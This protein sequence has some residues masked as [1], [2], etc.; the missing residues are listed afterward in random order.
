M[1]QR[2]QSIFLFL[3]GIVS[4]VLSHFFDL[5][6]IGVEWMQ[7]NDYEVI[8][9]LFLSSGILSFIVI[10]LFR[11]RRRQI[12]YNSINILINV[13]LVG[14]LIY[15][16]FNLPG[17]GFA[18][19]KGVGVFLPFVTILLLFLANRSIKKDEKLVKSV[20]RIR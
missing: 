11:N 18:S 4:L 6:R 7:A 12:I 5:W 10:F 8:W 16:L 19:E 17:E 14:L 2:V 1:I 9:A 15:R 20:D 3:A 13:V